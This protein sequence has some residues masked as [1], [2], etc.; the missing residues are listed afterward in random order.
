MARG[1]DPA[2]TPGI[3]VAQL[4]GTAR[5]LLREKAD[6]DTCL[7]ELHAVTTDPDLLGQAAG[8]ALG[9]WRRWDDGAVIGHDGDRVARML[10]AAGA[11]PDVRD[12]RADEVEQRLRTDGRRTGIGNP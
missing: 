6:V 3:I 4:D 11:D 5:R 1:D 12:R 7:R 2:R 9:A 8:A 10:T